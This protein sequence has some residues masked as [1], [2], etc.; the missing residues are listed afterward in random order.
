MTLQGGGRERT[1]EV[2]DVRALGA[3]NERSTCQAGNIRWECKRKG[4]ANEMAVLKAGECTN[5]EGKDETTRVR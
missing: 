2:V 5:C 1:G 4:S 3:C